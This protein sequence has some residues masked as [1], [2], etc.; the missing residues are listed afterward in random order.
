MNVLVAGASGFIGGHLVNALIDRGDE[1]YSVARKPVEQ[2]WQHPSK[3]HAARADLRQGLIWWGLTKIDV[4]V[5]LAADM[6]GIGFISA[7]PADCMANALINLNLLRGSVAL[8][9]K[10]Y[11]FA[12]SACVYSTRTD[13]LRES[14]VYPAMPDNDYGWEKLFSERATLAFAKDYGLDVRVP[15]FHT[16]YGPYGT[17]TGGREKV[18]AA[19]CRKVAEAVRDGSGEIEIWGDGEQ[20]RSFM[21]VG[22]AVE[23]I[24]RLIDSDV[25][26]PIN[27]G[28]AEQVTINEL[29]SIVERVAGVQL[30]RR[31]VVGPQGVRGRSSDNT[32]IR[33][34]LGWEPSTPLAE[35]IART[36]P[37]IA[38]QVNRQ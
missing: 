24:L 26:E 28:S 1:V 10:K 5:N 37:W 21:W 17:W 31:Y 35:G 23:G 3:A 6:G 22:D 8:G 38:E 32:M 11:V 30:K 14:D 25:R 29:V 18:P 34:R 13:V 7:R 27:L 9:V 33:E 20:T 4:L 16:C 19:I 15:R 12:S 2:W 36:Y